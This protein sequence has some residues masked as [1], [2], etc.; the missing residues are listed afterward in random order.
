MYLAINTKEGCVLNH[1]DGETQEKVAR[2]NRDI[3]R[4]KKGVHTACGAT[5]KQAR[6]SQGVSTWFSF[7][8][9]CFLSASLG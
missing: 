4:F 8:A 3:R 2:T 9:Q 6:A 5:T 1:M 7:S